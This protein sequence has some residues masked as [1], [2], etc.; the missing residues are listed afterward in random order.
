[1]FRLIHRILPTQDML[2]K[3]G[4]VE[5][6]LC[7]L[8]EEEI[9][10]LKHTFLECEVTKTFLSESKV[11]LLQITA[12]NNMIITKEHILF[13]TDEREHAFLDLVY[14]TAKQIIYQ[15][16]YN[17]SFP[18][19]GLLRQKLSKARKVEQIIAINN[20]KEIDFFEKWIFFLD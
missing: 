11:W 1:M 16:K 4:Y 18:T 19:L 13:G 8:C 2:K 10:S 15:N 3:W 5:S 7:T 12:K 17:T 6:D 9:D 14:L 20:G